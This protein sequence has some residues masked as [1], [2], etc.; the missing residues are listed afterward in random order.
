MN[1]SEI[2]LLLLIINLGITLG[3]GLYESRIVVPLWFSKTTKGNYRVNFESMLSIDTGRRFW[4][5]ITTIPLTL[6]T[7]ANIVAAI[8]SLGRAH[9][10]WLAASV[11]ILLERV[12]TFA[13]FIPGAIKLQRGKNLSVPKTTRL[14]S[15]WIRLNYVRN[16]LTLLS[17]LLTL[18][19]WSL[20]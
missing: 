6:L 1:T 4:G 15:W 8:Q 17:W 5:F 11:I 9:D 20:L 7:I 13:F 18:K 16:I 14:V 12:G 10:W 2:L 3:A 19:T